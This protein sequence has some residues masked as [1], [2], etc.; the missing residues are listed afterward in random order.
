MS[1]KNKV[2]KLSEQDI[3]LLYKLYK[4]RA[5]STAQLAE[6]GDLGKAYVYK[7]ISKLRKGGYLYSEQIT[8]GYIPNQKRQGSYHRISGKGI[9]L[10]KENDYLIDYTAEDLKVAKY[11]LAYLLTANDLA[12]PLT[13]NGWEYRDSRE[14]KNIHGLNRGDLLQGTLTNPNDDKEYI[15]Y[16][17]LKK[18]QPNSLLR[19]KNE[20]DRNKF[21][22][23]LVLTRGKDSFDSTVRSFTDEK[24]KLIKGGSIKV[25]PFGFARSYLNISI[26]NPE[27]H[28]HFIQELGLEILA[29][30]S[31]KNAFETNVKF[32]YLVKHNNEQKY[33]IDLL[34]NDLTK[35]GEIQHYRKEEFKRDGRKVLALTSSEKFHKQ[36]HENLLKDMQHIEYFIVDAQKVVDFGFELSN[37]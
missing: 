22:N 10:L 35:I 33:F 7:K 16:V 24:D 12:I 15:L 3:E 17:L 25:L 36:T 14:F 23:I 8:G 37:K 31:N 1:K 26:D 27:R 19:I 18:V 5:L 6:V 30:S 20:I 21:Q 13:E 34:D 9:T 4:Y 2:Q 29:D 11:R 28:K 32:D